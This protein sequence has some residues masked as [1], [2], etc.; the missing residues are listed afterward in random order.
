[1]KEAFFKVMSFPVIVVIISL[2]LIIECIIYM[3]FNKAIYLKYSLFNKVIDKIDKYID[4]TEKKDED[5]DRV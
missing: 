2:T 4:W 1:M 3:T 5:R